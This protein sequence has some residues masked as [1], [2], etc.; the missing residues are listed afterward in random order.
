[1]K[2]HLKTCL[3]CNE[4]FVSK[5]SDAKYCSNACRQNS[6]LIYKY[7]LH[8]IE[9]KR[10]SPEKITGQLLLLT[11][12]TLFIFAKGYITKNDVESLS[13][14]TSILNSQLTDLPEHNRV[15]K[16]LMTI[17]Q[18]LSELFNETNEKT[19]HLE[20][21][22]FHLIKYLETIL[23]QSKTAFSFVFPK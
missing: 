10:E 13:D 21:A 20:K 4:D 7:G 12:Q 8:T 19:L 22:E 23:S 17:C 16:K 9:Q 14:K 1:M 18:V 6:Y 15:L 11:N 2:N 3:D 5:R